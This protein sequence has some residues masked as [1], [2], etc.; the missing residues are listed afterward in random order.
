[1]VKLWVGDSAPKGDWIYY[2]AGVALFFYSVSRWPISFAFA[3]V[4]LKKLIKISFIELIFKFIF[5]LILFKHFSYMAPLIGM[6]LIHIIYV[7]RGIKTS[8]SFSV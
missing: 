2:I 7:A 1:M 6:I 8:N 5:T 4:K 3:Q